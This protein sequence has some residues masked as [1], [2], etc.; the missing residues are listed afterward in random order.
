ME[1]RFPRGNAMSKVFFSI[2][3]GFRI[4]CTFF[5]PALSVLGINTRRFILAVYIKEEFKYKIYFRVKN[6]VI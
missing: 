5:G 4:P 6:Y 1:N 3:E 2:F